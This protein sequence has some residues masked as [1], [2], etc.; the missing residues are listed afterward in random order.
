MFTVSLNLVFC[1]SGQDETSN[2]TSFVKCDSFDGVFATD[3]TMIQC[4]GEGVQGHKV[5]FD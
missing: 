1:S 5:V 2:R 4:P 3:R